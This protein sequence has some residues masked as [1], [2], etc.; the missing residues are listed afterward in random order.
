[1]AV[2]M[3]PSSN[4]LTP[5]QPPISHKAY[6]KGFFYILCDLISMTYHFCSYGLKKSLKKILIERLKLKK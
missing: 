4:K 5:F 2:Q 6:N 1:M 3:P